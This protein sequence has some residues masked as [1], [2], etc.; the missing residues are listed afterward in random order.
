MPLRPQ[1]RTL[2]FV[3]GSALFGSVMII[4]QNVVTGPEMSR[5]AVASRPRVRRAKA[6]YLYAE[7]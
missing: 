5:V 1:H 6:K 4:A 3:V 7:L 2:V